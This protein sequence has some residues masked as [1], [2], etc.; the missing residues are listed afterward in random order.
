MKIIKV[1]D[2]KEMSDRAAEIVIREIKKKPNLV[3]G[4]ATGRTPIGLYRR[5]VRAYKKG[6]ISFSK[7]KA[8][9]LDE[10]YPIKRSDK[11][12]YYF[13]I[14]KRLF[15]KVDIKKIDVDILNGEAKDW[16]KECERYEAKIKK[17]PID[18]QILGI[19]VN[20]HIGF[21][22]PGSSFESKTRIINLTGV[23]VKRNSK[24]LKN[25]LI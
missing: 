21:N 17:N 7:I 5:L 18:L 1:K 13:Y 24:I 20:G 12:S 22:E 2:Y 9:N 3:L 15:N 11:R 16:K 4:C 23:T 19:G 6:E 8:F 10:Y 14:F 25:N